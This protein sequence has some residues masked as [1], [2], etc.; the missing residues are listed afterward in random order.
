MEKGKKRFEP[1]KFRKYNKDFS[2]LFEKEKLNLIRL[3]GNNVKIEH[4]GST[5]VPNLGGKGILDILIGAEKKQIPKIKSLLIKNNY[6]FRPKGGTKKRLFFRKDY[7]YDN[8]LIRYHIHL[9]F[10]TSNVWKHD[11]FVRDFL[12]KNKKI[13]REYENIK[14]QGIQLS[15]GSGKIYKKHKHHFL[16]N[17]I[18]NLK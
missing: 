6:L 7:Y 14:K 17:L 18:N 10:L 5:A 9:T 16:Q 13:A 8:K 15:K 3:M 2:K 12:I 1:Y 11:L 4:I